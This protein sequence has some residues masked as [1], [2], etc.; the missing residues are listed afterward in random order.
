[1]REVNFTTRSGGL[2]LLVEDLAQ[3]PA[4]HPL[5]DHVNLAPVF[6]DIDLHYAG[7]VHVLADFL[8]TAKT[9]EEERVALHFGM[10][11]LDGDL[12]TVAQVSG[13]EDGSHAAACDKFIQTVV[14][15]LLVDA[16]RS[17]GKPGSS[18]RRAGVLLI[19][20][21]RNQS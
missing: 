15:E 11:N 12:A 10:R 6:V 20:D 17:H 16:N 8:F 3:K 19:N 13:A 2:L 4:V 7:M 14:I 1:M 18:T 9:V 5:H 21:A